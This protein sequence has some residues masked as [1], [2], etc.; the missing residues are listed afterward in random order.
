LRTRTLGL[1]GLAITTIGVGAW[2]M[3]GG[4]WSGGY[5][6]QDDR[7]SVAAIHRALELGV[8]W[9]DTA[10]IYGLGHS[11]E[12]VG[13]ALAGLAEPPL[14][15]T[16]CSLV[17]NEAGDVVTDLRASSI[18]SECEQSLR[19]LGIDV[20]DLYQIHWPE[21]DIGGSLEEAWETLRDLRREGKVRHIGGSNFVIGHLDRAGAIAPVASLQPSYSLLERGAEPELL[22]RCLADG[23]GVIVYSP[24]ASGLLT[25]TWTKGRAA[26]LPA[27]DWRREDA[28]FSGDGLERSLAVAGRVGELAAGLGCSAGELAIAWTLA[29][30]AVTG[31]IVGVRTPAQVDALV[32]AAELDLGASALA[33]LGAL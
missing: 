21:P 26:A 15:F 28:K 20:I 1:S 12:V 25:D 6:D 2:A 19:R 30:P 9:I 14:V 17:Q 10:P 33:A 7:D 18:R 16:K 5:G 13:R 24:M 31:A 29:N 22:P 27:D 32:G 3:G 4:G 11:E 8:N 23:I